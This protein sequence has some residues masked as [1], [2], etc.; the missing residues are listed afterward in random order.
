M[1]IGPIFARE[2]LTTPRRPRH[3]L[4]R[5]ACAGLFFVLMWTAWQAVIGFQKVQRLSDL[6]YFSMLLFQLLTYTQLVLVVFS[7]ALYGT[8][9][10]S[11]EKDRRTFILLM[12]TRLTDSEIV[13]NKF[14]CGLLQITSALVTTFPVFMICALLGGVAFSQII[15]VYAVTFGAAFISIATGTL[16]AVWRE[17]TFQAVALTI[18]TVTL[19]LL[20]VEVFT[21]FVGDAVWNEIPASVWCAALSPF[22]ALAEVLNPF[23]DQVRQLPYVKSAG[24]AYFAL[25]TLLSLSFLIFSSVMLRRWNPRGEPIQQPD[26]ESVEELAKLTKEQRDERIFRRIWKNPVLWRETMTRAYGTKPVLIKLAYFLVFLPLLGMLWTMEP[27][28]ASSS[29]QIAGLALLP[30]AVL[31]LLLINAQAV[32]S[33]TSE[34]DLK[35]LDLL[36][37]TEVSPREFVFGKLAGIFY[38]TKEMVVAP[39]VFLLACAYH[40][41]ISLEGLAYTVTCIAVF[42]IFAAVLGVHAA[43]RF[44]STRVAL[45]NSLGTMFLLFVGIV[46]CWY[47]VVVSGGNLQ[48]QF[49]SFIL[50]IVLG[51]IGLWLS[52]S[53]NA[54]SNAIG[55]TAAVTPV[56]TFYCLI[57]FVLGEQIGPFLV[58]AGVYAFA[59]LS[60]LVP[61]LAEFDV[62][63]GRTTHEEG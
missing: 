3:Y 13:F 45:A 43:L 32:S 58:S 4:L 38:N 23:T 7:A 51:S 37:V 11:H 5:A 62:A 55:L 52:L 41:L 18:L 42:M 29:H 9:A 34:R 39:F 53:A 33:V 10:I 28:S 57:A 60:L 15:E 20:S 59:V 6:A 21:W 1:L 24:W 25:S 35:S 16:I 40:R 54:P 56:A 19:G 12:I 27:V 22:R 8:S 31:S 61:L 47:L 50:F 30:I 17:Q 63:T 14:Y 44:K 26:S 46:I 49:A 36:L 48:A 2:L